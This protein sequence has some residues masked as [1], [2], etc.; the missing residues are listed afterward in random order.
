MGPPQP[1]VLRKESVSLSEATLR[2]MSPGVPCDGIV[3]NWGGLRLMV[4]TGTTSLTE[5]DG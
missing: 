1:V 5:S 4:D 2:M 3:V